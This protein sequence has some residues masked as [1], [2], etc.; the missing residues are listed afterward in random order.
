MPS[1]SDYNI[2]GVYARV[3]DA[4]QFV[5][6]SVP[7]TV[8][9][10]GLASKGPMQTPTEIRS[11]NDYFN[12]FGPPDGSLQ[13]YYAADAFFERGNRMWFT[14]VESAA[15]P[16]VSG[17]FT[18]AVSGGTAPVITAISKGTWAHD[19]DIYISAGSTAG[20][21]LEVYY[22]GAM[23]ESYDNIAVAL[24]IVIT[25]ING[26]SQYIT[27]TA[28]AVAGNVTVPQNG[29]LACAA[30]QNGATGL[31]AA[32]II[33]TAVGATRTDLNQRVYDMNLV[34][35]PDGNAL[36]THAA[37]LT[38]ASTRGDLIALVDP[39][40]GLTPT[41][42][43][44]FAAGFNSSW[45]ASYY[46]WLKMR[47]EKN[48]MDV[49]TPP[50]GHIAG[51]IAFN[52]K[53][54][55][56]WFACAGISRGTLTKALA[57]RVALSDPNIATLYAGSARMNPIIQRNGIVINGHK[58]LQSATTALRYSEVRRGLIA[59]RSLAEQ[60]VRKT[61]FNPGN[62]RFYRELEANMKP[63]IEF[64]IRERAF[65]DLAFRC[66]EK[67]NVAANRRQHIVKAQFYC[68]PNIAVDVIIL[69]IVL[70]A[71]GLNF[72]ESVLTA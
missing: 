9:M 60:V 30:G 52:D 69:N 20:F 11:I 67:T 10:V 28:G 7:L 3:L 32:D 46:P 15:T 53:V 25:G 42:A 12:I 56:P 19:I 48:I 8:G 66:N 57:T 62:S 27:I 70:T 22:L 24:P 4:T 33:G 71:E 72:S 64:M 5:A 29:T 1:Y 41:T 38:L 43:A 16:A 31:A 55:W 23:V 68:K 54:K 39:A 51:A 50:S 34:M 36:A 40:D 6:E 14:R 2:P 37:L 13:S 18:L 35:A 63:V 45:G 58:T 21:K 49:W 61:Q 17:T 65:R 26:V 47:D 44:A 59:L